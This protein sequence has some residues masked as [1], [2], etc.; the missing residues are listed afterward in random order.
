[1]TERSLFQISLKILRLKASFPSTCRRVFKGFYE[2][3]VKMVSIPPQYETIIYDKC[4]RCNDKCNLQHLQSKA[5][6][7]SYR[8]QR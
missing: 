5:I 7:F 6:F 4:N 1:M 3:H 2:R 8:C